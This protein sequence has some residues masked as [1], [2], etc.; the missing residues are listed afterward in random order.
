MLFE[1]YILKEYNER[2]ENLVSTLAMQEDV[3]MIKKRKNMALFLSIVIGAVLLK[4]L[5]P[6]LS[7]WFA[8]FFKNLF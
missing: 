2:E 8:D 1:V 6:G 7:Y 4:L 3:S 5:F